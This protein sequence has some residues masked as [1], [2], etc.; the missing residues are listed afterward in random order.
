[1]PL[2]NLNGTISGGTFNNVAGNLN[3]NHIINVHAVPL[4]ASGSRRL[5]EGQDGLISAP[6]TD[7]SIGAIRRQRGSGN[8]GGRPYD[9]T[10]RNRHYVEQASSTSR[11]ATT[12]TPGGPLNVNTIIPPTIHDD[13]GNNH[14]GPGH[15]LDVMEF[16]VLSQRYL[17]APS[18][19]G[20]PN[21]TFNSVAGNMVSVTSYGESGIEILRLSVV[22]EAL[23]DSGERFPEPACH[24]GTRTAILK[25]LTSWAIDTTP[26]SK[27]MWLHGP[28]GVGKSAIAQ[29]FAGSCHGEGRLGGSFFF[30]RGHPN[31][32]T[33]HGLVATITYQLCILLPNFLTALQE[34]VKLDKL[35][36]GRALAVQFQRL[37][38]EPFQHVP[39]PK[40]FP[41]IVIDGLDECEDH[42]VQQQVVR[43]LIQA[44]QDHRIPMRILITGRPEPHLREIL[45]TDEAFAICRQLTLSADASAYKD[46]RAY[47]QREFSR[48][49]SHSLESGVDLGAVW[50]PA[51]AL[52]HLVI[53]SSGIFVYAT[54]VIQYVEDEYSHPEQRL[55]S[56]L[57]LD[58]QSTTPLDDLYTSI[59]SVMPRIPQNLQ[60]LHVLYPEKGRSPG[61]QLNPEKID[62]LFKLLPGT[63]RRTLRALHSLLR[64][65]PIST[66]SST[67]PGWHSDPVTPLHASFFDFLVDVR[68]SGPWCITSPDLESDCLQSTLRLLSTPPPS[69]SAREFYRQL[70]WQLPESLGNAL[71]SDSLLHLLRNKEFQCS[72]HLVVKVAFEWPQR[73]SSYPADLIQLWEDH[74]FTSALCDNLYPSN[75]SLATLKFDS[76]YM[77]ILSRDPALLIV[78]RAMTIRGS[79]TDNIIDSLG[80]TYQVFRPLL[81]FRELTFP[82]SNGDSPIDFLADPQ[83]AGDLYAYSAEEV[84]L[85][86]IRRAKEAVIRGE[87]RGT[88]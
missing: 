50:P 27:I 10:G 14:A 75:R 62:M 26:T 23:H 85:A 87:G 31:R 6:T 73:H 71:P 34:A 72:L 43:L 7:S 42:K 11:S 51:D 63:S 21:V 18:T 80:C 52:E 12:N 2:I 82:F 15:N 58:P 3:I 61:V 4:G 49:S 25:K 44:V 54:T 79:G 17:G 55:Q 41:V 13:A 45:E 56:V 69:R 22:K 32:G 38:V 19:A 28:A 66:V 24:P 65:P 81:V 57:R 86:W 29:M 36:V 8:D 33:W 53:K 77:D 59:L 70:V 67:P 20:A 5:I 16:E 46:I 40:I 88:L 76:M 83:R 39:A 84:I 1:M 78:L 47:L 37:L 35:V 30:R 60:I 64:V 48:I 74:Q 68:R 9:I